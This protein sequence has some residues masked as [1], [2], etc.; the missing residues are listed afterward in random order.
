MSE[1]ILVIEVTLV[2][3]I[4]IDNTSYRLSNLYLK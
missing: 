4:N 1:K 2:Q 3:N